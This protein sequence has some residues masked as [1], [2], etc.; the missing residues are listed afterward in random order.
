MENTTKLN[1]NHWVEALSNDN[2]YLLQPNSEHYD[3]KLAGMLR[4]AQRKIHI[5][6]KYPDT[7]SGILAEATHLLSDVED[8]L[9]KNF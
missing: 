3:K 5:G 7:S 9:L 8:Y 6:Y 4:E 2:S 1:L